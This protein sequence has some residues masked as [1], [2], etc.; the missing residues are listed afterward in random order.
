MRSPDTHAGRSDRDGEGAWLV[1][2]TFTPPIELPDVGPT[3]QA[4]LG[5]WLWM[6]FGDAGLIGIDEGSIDVVEAFA[7]GV[8]GSP[9]VI[10][11]AA[12]PTER[13][14]I[15]MAAAGR[16]ALAFTDERSCREAVAVLEG[17]AGVIALPRA[18]AIPDAEPQRPVAVDG[19]GWIL[20]PGTPPPAGGAAPGPGLVVIDAGIGFGTGLHA[21]TRLCLRAI[22]ARAAGGRLD[23][24]LDVGAGSGILGIAAATLGATHVDAIEIDRGV[25]DAIRRNAAASGVAAR[26]HVAETLFAAAPGGHQPYDLVVANI[27]AGVLQDLA[28]DL[29]RLVAAGGVL[30]LSGILADESPAVAARYDRVGGGTTAVTTE[31]GWACL[32]IS[33]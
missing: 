10:D 15:G 25:H 20:P 18:A 14:W 12:A 29:V 21:T 26:I 3:D 22:A 17:I 19:F 13:D 28:A 5:E 1:S 33:H 6:R 27:V 16:L 7:A 11:T 32:T 9:L 23:R 8:A 30:V 31:D 4:G 2:V 24:V